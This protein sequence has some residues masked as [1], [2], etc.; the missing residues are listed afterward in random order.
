MIQIAIV[1]DEKNFYIT[2]KS[3]ITKYEDKY[4]EKFNIEW[5]ENGMDFLENY[6]S[7]FDM[8]FMD[9]NMPNI[10]GMEASKEIRLIDNTVLI[11]FITNLAQYAIKGYEVDALDYVL[12]PITYYDFE[13]KMTRAVRIIRER[14]GKGIMLK[15]DDKT[16]KI[17]LKD[18]LYIE[19]I[20]HKIIFH[21]FE[22]ISISTGTLKNI[23]KMLDSNMFGRCNSCY[24]VNFMH[25]KYIKDDCILIEKE[26]LK[27]SRSKKNKFVEQ[28][29]NY[30][31]DGGR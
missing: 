19:I 7:N 24:L 28:F 30:Y 8:I 3:F 29:S 27:M 2:L 13:L 5:F 10:N 9:I 21:T 16:K 12:K 26:I 20:S 6:K 14:A 15:F 4:D 23:E 25:V 11:I 1:E 22:G 17:L 31:K 18:I